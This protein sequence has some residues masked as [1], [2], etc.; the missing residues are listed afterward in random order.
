[1]EWARA[2]AAG[3]GGLAQLGSL[4]Y[5][6]RCTCQVELGDGFAVDRELLRLLEGQLQRCGPANLTVP[7]PCPPP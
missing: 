7:A 3:A 5:G 4:W 1:M 6:Q 2:A